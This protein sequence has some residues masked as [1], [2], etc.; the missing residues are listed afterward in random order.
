[1]RQRF[2]RQ[3]PTVVDLYFDYRIP[4]PLP[5][6][7]RAKTGAVLVPVYQCNQNRVR[8]IARRR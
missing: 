3:W 4:L 6:S 8:L 1:M 2:G 5:H 7:I